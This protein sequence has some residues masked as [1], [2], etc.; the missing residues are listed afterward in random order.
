M[1][2]DLF[3]RARACGNRR[4]LGSI[5]S[6]Q[7]MWFIGERGGTTIGLEAQNDLNFTKFEQ[8]HAP[9]ERIDGKLIFAEELEQARQEDWFDRLFTSTL[10]VWDET[11]QKWKLVPVKA[12]DGGPINRGW[13]DRSLY[14]W[15]QSHSRGELFAEKLWRILTWPVEW[16]E[17]GMVKLRQAY[18]DNIRSHAPG[19][20]RTCN[21]GCWENVPL[22][23][24][25]AIKWLRKRG[26]GTLAGKM[27]SSKV[28]VWKG[29]EWHKNMLNREHMDILEAA[30]R[31][32]QGSIRLLVGADGIEKKEVPTYE[33]LPKDYVRAKY[34]DPSP[35]KQYKLS[36]DEE[37][38]QEGWERWLLAVKGESNV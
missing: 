32:R 38:G 18:R 27:A 13:A 20:G 35:P 25:Q 15:R 37:R 7:G 31:F 10:R 26:K 14:L 30:L 3:F 22:E 21:D 2:P 8:L 29:E 12:P 23:G 24:T 6:C 16:A 5:W 33:G 36:L 28:R 11:E 19:P 34:G 9:G 4:N 1:E 17:A